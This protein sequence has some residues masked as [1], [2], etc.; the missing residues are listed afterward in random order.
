MLPWSI[1]LGSWQASPLNA[2]NIIPFPERVKTA[3][4]L[5]ACVAK[6]TLPSHGLE[7]R[8][9]RRQMTPLEPSFTQAVLAEKQCAIKLEG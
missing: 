1:S 2:F 8:E 6:P 7:P 9:P 5:M 4:P 3:V